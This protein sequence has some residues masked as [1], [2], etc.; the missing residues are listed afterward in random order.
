M[1][2]T[3]YHRKRLNKANYPASYRKLRVPTAPQVASCKN[4]SSF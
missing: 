2:Q 3:F 4:T 1:L